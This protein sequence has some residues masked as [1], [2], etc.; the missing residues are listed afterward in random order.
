MLRRTFVANSLV[1]AALSAASASD[2]KATAGSSSKS[3]SGDASDPA[4]ASQAS[5]NASAQI[6]QRLYYE[7]RRYQLVNGPQKKICDAFFQNAFIPAVNK[8]GIT[9]VGVFHLTV[10]PGTPAMYVL[11]PSAS[12]D[13]LMNLEAHLA[14]DVQYM[15]AGTPFLS[16]PAVAPAFQRLESQLMIAFEKI[17]G[18]TLPAATAT[19]A[20]RVFELRT[21][22]SSTD[23]D[24]RRKVEM[25]QSG[26]ELIFNKA[27]FTQVFYGDTLIGGHLPNL[28][29]MLSF[30]SLA[31]RDQHWTAFANN[32]EWKTM[33]A[34]PRYSFEEIVSN[35]SN[36]ILTPAPYSQ[37]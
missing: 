33:Q 26:E 36:F 10:G 22:E 35:I 14:N 9:P 12:L 19:N 3:S 1:V 8:L 11:L 6:Q 28:T 5:A 2:S 31:A 34:N 13:A 18:I 16:A 27:G 15:S 24:H 29:Y 20:A 17:P 32:P 25:M 37:I 21:Y 4:T 30:E 23:L 7:L